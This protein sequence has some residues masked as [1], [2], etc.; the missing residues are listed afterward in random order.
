[1]NAASHEKQGMMSA[2][3][4]SPVI[5]LMLGACLLAGCG[6]SGTHPVTGGDAFP[7]VTL[8][9][10]L[11]AEAFDLIQHDKYAQAEPLLKRAIDTDVTFGPARNNLGLVYLHQGNWYAAAW[12]FQNAIK[13]MPHQPEPRNNLGLVLE[14]AGKFGDAIEAYE[15]ARKMEP[16]NPE[17][18]GN[19]ARARVLRGDR[20]A[21]TKQ[22]LQEL[23]FKDSRPKWRDWAQ[24]MLLQQFARPIDPNAPAPPPK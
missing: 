15:R 18:I 21:E 12:E 23:A 8:A 3:T 19:L 11:N 9:R 20:D 2:V 24:M 6:G 22:L 4:K 17:F 7:N 14:S 16:D 5:L 1:M 13:L 10:Q